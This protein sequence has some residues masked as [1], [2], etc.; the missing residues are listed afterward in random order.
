MP[1][2]P[3]R[4]PGTGAPPGGHEPTSGDHW[5]VLL[6]QAYGGPREQWT[7]HI[8][9]LTREDAERRARDV[10][11]DPPR[12]LPADDWPDDDQADRTAL[13]D[14]I[15]ITG[16]ATPCAWQTARPAGNVTLLSTEPAT[17]AD[18]GLLSLTPAE[19]AALAVALDGNEG[20]ADA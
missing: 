20:Q 1:T 5:H 11:A 10:L 3:A 2:P 6:A 15:W 8:D 12:E 4:Q 7:V 19:L 16:C 13:L 18:L 9:E 14:A 17:P